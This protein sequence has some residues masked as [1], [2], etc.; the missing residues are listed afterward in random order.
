LSDCLLDAL[1]A[2]LVSE[3]A[4]AEADAALQ[5]ELEEAAEQIVSDFEKGMSDV[6]ENLE[7]AQ[8]AFDDLSGQWPPADAVCQL[9]VLL[10]CV[11]VKCCLCFER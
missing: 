10:P 5:R 7:K 1:L 3:S 4:D 11:L 2:L 6:M 8:L 9:C